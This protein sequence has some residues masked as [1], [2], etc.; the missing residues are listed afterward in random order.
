LEADLFPSAPTF[1]DEP[2][3]IRA[4]TANC[5]LAP[6]K[7][8]ANRFLIRCRC[9][10]GLYGLFCTEVFLSG[11]ASLS[12]RLGL[13]YLEEIFPSKIAAVLIPSRVVSLCSVAFFFGRYR[14]RPVRR[15]DGPS[16]PTASTFF[17]T[18]LSAPRPPNR[19]RQRFPRRLWEPPYLFLVAP[20]SSLF[21]S[22]S[23][24]SSC[25]LDRGLHCPSF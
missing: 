6:F 7:G 5:L 21:R 4:L 23:G 2:S 8:S 20:A 22:T 10:R 11:C 12:V 3:R 18:F 15:L 25:A 24:A 9:R 14:V 16:R 13:L 1:L 19:L 17:L